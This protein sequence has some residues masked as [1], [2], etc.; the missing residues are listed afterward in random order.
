MHLNIFVSNNCFVYCKGCYSYSREEKISKL[1]PSE[2]IINFLEYAYKLGIKKVTI[3]GGDPLTRKDIIELLK[4]I[5]SIGFKIS[6]D[7]L[8]TNII[9]DVKMKNKIVYNK[10]SAKELSELVDVIGI[11][12]DGSNNQIIKLFRPTN[13]DIINNQIKVC[14]ELSKYNASIC[15][16]T[17]VYKGNL[18]DANNICNL[19]KTLKIKEWQLFQFEP[20]GKFGLLNRK[21][22]EITDEEFS[23]Y[24]KEILK[25]FQDNNIKITFKNNNDRINKYM[26]IDNFGNAW[27]PFLEKNNRKIIGNIKNRENWQDICSYINNV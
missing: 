11:P 16:N 1:L 8:G 20:L 26:L 19:I 14:E 25:N 15:I 4:R 17:V 12:I 2:N 9:K 27:V 18:N 21:M 5:K 22:F 3:C 7:T 24:K 13:M 10:I 6:L 23:K